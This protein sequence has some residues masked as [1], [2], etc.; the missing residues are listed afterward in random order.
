VGTV[1]DTFDVPCSEAFLDVHQLLSKGMRLPQK[2]WN[3]GMHACG[4]KK[5]C[6]V[7]LWNKRRIRNQTMPI[8]DKEIQEQSL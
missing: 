6:R 7:I 8:L 4:S 1:P 5:N 2:V 3:K